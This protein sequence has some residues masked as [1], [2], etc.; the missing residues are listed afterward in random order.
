VQVD[1]VIETRRWRGLS[2]TQHA[3]VIVMAMHRRTGLTRAFAW[4]VSERV[5][6]D[7]G[8]AVLL[9]ESHGKRLDWIERLLVPVD[10]TAGGAVVLSAAVGLLAQRTPDWCCST[11]CRPRL[12]GVTVVSSLA[13][14]VRDD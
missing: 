3:D 7:T 12:Y 14:V 11:L 2:S 1:S 10:G 4:R 13:G 9:F 6:A 5:V 8:R